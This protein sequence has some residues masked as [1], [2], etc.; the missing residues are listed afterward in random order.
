M[1]NPAKAA[2]QI[3]EDFVSYVTTSFKFD[4]EDYN[5]LFHDELESIVS[6]GP[7]VDLNDVFKTSSSL[8]M[9]IGNDRKA[10]ISPLFRDLEKN[11]P[12]DENHKR[13]APLNRPLYLHQKTTLLKCVQGKN[14]VV[15][16]GTGSGKTECFLYPII[17]ELLREKEDKILPAKGVRAILIYPM[18]ALA[19]DQMKR[20]RE[21]LM[22]YPDITFGVFSGDTEKTTSS[23]NAIY[24]QIHSQEKSGELR[25]RLTNELIS[26]EEI[27]TTPPNILITNY[28]MLERLLFIPNNDSIF[29][30]SSVKFIVLDESHVYRGA[31]GMETA[32]LFRRLKARLASPSPIQFILT[33]ATLGKPGESEEAIS[34]FASNL[35]GEP[36]DKDDIIFGARNKTELGRETPV[37]VEPSFFLDVC[38]KGLSKNCFSSHH[39][40][41]EDSI[42]NEENLYNACFRSTYYKLLRENYDG[43]VEISKVSEWLQIPEDLCISFLFACTLASKQGTQLID[44]RYHFFIRALDGAFATIHGPKKLFL[45]RKDFVDDGE[46]KE[47]VFEIARCPYCGDLALVGNIVTDETNGGSVFAMKHGILPDFRE[48]SSSEPEYFHIVKDNDQNSSSDT[49][50]DDNLEEKEKESDEKKPVK[51]KIIQYWLCPHCGKVEAV[52]NGRPRC[53]HPDADFIKIECVEESQKCLECHHD[54]Y[55]R[56]YLGSEAPTSILGMSLFEQLP[57]KKMEATIGNG[58]KISFEGGKQFLCFSDSRSEAAFFTSYENKVYQTYIGRRGL[59]NLMGL[60][61]D[62]IRSKGFGYFTFDDLANELGKFFAKHKSFT[63]DLIHPEEGKQLDDISNDNAWRVLLDQLVTFSR[64]NSLQTMGFLQFHYL[65]NSDSIVRNYQNKYFH[66]VSEEKVRS[67]LNYLAMSFV[68]TGSIIPKRSL[69]SDMLTFVFFSS[70]QNTMILRKTGGDGPHTS[71]WLP[72]NYEGKDKIYPNSRFRAAMRLLPNK[73]EKTAID[74]LADYFTTCLT[75]PSNNEKSAVPVSNHPGYAMPTNCF[76]IAVSGMQEAKWFRCK[77]CGRITSFNFDDHCIIGE[78]DGELEPISDPKQYFKNDYYYGVYLGT[79]LK[80]LLIKEHTGQ[81]DRKHGQKY[82]EMFEKNEINALSCSTTFEMGVDVGELE[83]VFLRDVPPTA[84]NYVQRTGRAG[85]SKDSSAFALTY[86]K[87]SSHDF[88]YFANPIDMIGGKIEPPVFKLDNEKIVERHIYSVCLSYFFAKHPDCFDDNQID[89]F[90]PKN[91]KGYELFKDLILKERPQELTSLLQR[92]FGASLDS[93]FGISSYKGKWVEELVGENGRL[94]SAI[95]KYRSDVDEFDSLLREYAAE[96]S[97]GHYDFAKRIDATNNTKR[98]YEGQ[99]MINFLVD[100]NVL[101]K[102]GFPVDT[103]KLQQQIH[104]KDNGLSLNRGMSQAIG[105]YAP[106]SKVIAD[107]RMYT[108]RYINKMPRNGVMGFDEGEVCECPNCGTMNY[109][110]LKHNGSETCVGCGHSLAG[111]TGFYEAITPT[112]GMTAEVGSE[113][114]PMEKPGRSYSSEEHYVGRDLLGSTRLFSVNGHHI[115]IIST[116]N[117]SI[118]V[119]SPLKHPFYVCKRCGFALGQYDQ[120]KDE[121]GKKNKPLTATLRKGLAPVITT[122]AAHNKPNTGTP[123]GEKDLHKAILCYVYNTDIV[124]IL[125]NDVPTITPQTAYS[126]LYAIL[127]AISVSL[128]VEP[129][130]ISGCLRRNSS[131]ENTNISFVIYDTVP[132]GAGHVKRILDNNGENLRKIIRQALAKMNCDCDSSCYKCLRTYS[133]QKYHTLLDH[134]KAAE[135]LSEYSGEVVEEVPGVVSSQ[136]LTFLENGVSVSQYGK[137][138]VLQ[139]LAGPQLSAIVNSFLGSCSDIPD[140]DYFNSK[141]AS[142]LKMVVLRWDK[143]KVLLFGKSQSDYAKTLIGNCDWKVFVGD[144][145]FDKDLFLKA[146]QDN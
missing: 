89:Q 53:G 19:N 25:H 26:R 98:H 122:L 60:K 70:V 104:E 77:K 145:D 29:D 97:Q 93:E 144:D 10:S 109:F 117:D 119:T 65:G 49:D 35:T 8:N 83:T 127:G 22:F 118:M 54:D 5:R 23:A 1:F 9:L 36:F 138:V 111:S 64:K 99:Q 141:I 115:T 79:Y 48:A 120:I 51:N 81:I 45:E 123:C 39:V 112:G 16:T 140:P 137:S 85:R 63:S 72:R 67:L 7:Y 128:D 62:D 59:A 32:M 132:G 57:S 40:S 80:K 43:P 90:V 20:L 44:L 18:N 135:F 3:K 142:S 21:L 69:P 136:K 2:K 75:N 73:D 24:E 50:Y 107:E 13:K 30:N 66:G 86:A 17:N 28:A 46:F 106:G 124:R 103:V 56:F 61:S 47:K 6:K 134:K 15:T 58:L 14:I 133:N 71:S 95:D 11:K 41:F 76:G 42:P 31:T 114:V 27:L 129:S 131:S 102:Y 121:K 33:S 126:V 100:A 78:C 113:D 91:S 84:A 38:D 108:S 143:D 52:E 130:D 74:F 37:Y 92:S 139:H 68:S 116:E 88:N 105:D 146:F 110:S 12:N 96:I 94:Q 82:Q 55:S 34:Q 4:D 87:L 125:F 101:P